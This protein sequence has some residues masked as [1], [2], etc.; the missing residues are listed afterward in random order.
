[1]RADVVVPT[2]IGSYFPGPSLRTPGPC[3]EERAG[4][5][6]RR[7]DP[8]VEDPHLRAVAD[9][10]DVAVDRGEVAGAELADLVLGRGE[11]E[12]VLRHHAS[13]S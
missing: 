8:L 13:R 10:D 11:G 2:H 4:E 9:A 7:L 6:P 3:E 1:M 5:V 12:L